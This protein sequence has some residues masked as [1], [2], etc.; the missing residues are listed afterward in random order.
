MHVMHQNSMLCGE[1]VVVC[2]VDHGPSKQVFSDLE[3]DEE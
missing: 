1:T 3:K 2:I